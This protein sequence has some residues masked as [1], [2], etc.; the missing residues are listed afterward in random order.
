[1]ATESEI[2]LQKTQNKTGFES[3]PGSSHNLPGHKHV[4]SEIE[5]YIGKTKPSSKSVFNFG[6]E[7]LALMLS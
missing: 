4:L 2:T 6:P 7:L 1:M 3:H 5:N